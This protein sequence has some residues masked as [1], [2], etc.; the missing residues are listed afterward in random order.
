M[1]YDAN[2]LKGIDYINCLAE[3]NQLDSTNKINIFVD[4][5]ENNN[6]ITI[7]SIQQSSEQI[8]NN[9]ANSNVLIDLNNNI[10]LNDN[11]NVIDDT[12][13]TSNQNKKSLS[14]PKTRSSKRKLFANDE[15]KENL[16]FRMNL[17]PKRARNNKVILLIFF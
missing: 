16:T 4:S 13:T 8:K 10:V 12:S 7:A 6:N 11:G 2:I 9:F 17:R 5:D 15:N 1:E 14:I 3:S